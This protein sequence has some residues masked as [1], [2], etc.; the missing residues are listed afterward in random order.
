MTDRLPLATTEPAPAPPRTRRALLAGMLGGLGAWAAAAV[1]KI[2]P[3]EA[4]AGASLIIGSTTN[5]AGSSNTTLTTASTGT[6][7]L[8]T[9]NGS[10]TALR[11]S[12]VGAG[13]IAGFF[14]AN[15]GTGISGVTGNANSYGIYG[16]NDGAAGTGAAMRAYGG[17]NP[18][19]VATSDTSYGVRATS[20]S[21]PGVSA[22][23]TSSAGVWGTSTD[24]IGVYG[25]STNDTGISGGSFSGN[26]VEASGHGGAKDG[27]ALRSDNWNT[28]NGMAAYLTNSSSFATAHLYNAGSGQVLWLQN[29]GTD[30]AGTGGGDFIN[31]R[32]KDES[33]TQFRVASDGSAYSDGTFNGGGADFAELL[34]AVDGL[35]P[36]DV[37][38]VQPD[39]RLARSSA[40]RSSSVLGVY[41]TKPGFVGGSPL[42]GAPADH[43]PLAVVGIVPVKASAENGPIRAGDRLVS[44]ALPG[45]A[46]LADQ[47]P[48]VGT[49]IG[50]ALADLATGTGPLQMMVM[51][52]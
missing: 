10:G 7:L 9:Q 19:L 43:V 1:A 51:L 4:A 15:N 25:Y 22:S 46:M 14:T 35:E 16:A 18:G 28:S 36:G 47:H 8:I 13:S 37:L 6:G 24:Y 52:Q 27:A 40:A 30:A 34:P 50:K 20:T 42:G 41:S 17:A 23:S 11:G 49:V 2:S 31:C 21:G 44:A 5:N 33:D 38:A 29:G 45:Y 3:V 48:E 39:G 32:N 12:A 26:A